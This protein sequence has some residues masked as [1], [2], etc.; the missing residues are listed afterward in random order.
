MIGFCENLRDP[1]KLVKVQMSKHGI[2]K[3]EHFLLRLVSK[4]MIDHLNRLLTASGNPSNGKVC[5]D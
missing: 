2:K 5:H 3:L 1:T 4:P